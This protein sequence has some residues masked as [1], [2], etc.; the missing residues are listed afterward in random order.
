MTPQE[1]KHHSAAL[2]RHVANEV[3]HMRR[4]RQ[5]AVKRLEDME[6]HADNA[7]HGEQRIQAFIEQ[8]RGVT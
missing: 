3:L 1:Y 8:N 5:D 2:K 7:R 6:V 4:C